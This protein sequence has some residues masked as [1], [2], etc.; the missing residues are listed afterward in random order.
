MK[1]CLTPPPPLPPPAGVGRG[2]AAAGGSTIGGLAREPALQADP[3][4]DSDPVPGDS[5]AGTSVRRPEEEPC[6]DPSASG[7]GPVTLSGLRPRING[8]WYAPP[9]GPSSPVDTAWSGTMQQA[10]WRC[11]CSARLIWPL[12]NPSSS[13]QPSRRMSVWA[14]WL[15]ARASGYD[16]ALLWVLILERVGMSIPTFKHAT[17]LLREGLAHITGA[18]WPAPSMHSPAMSGGESAPCGLRVG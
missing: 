2:A 16:A 7:P 10:L 15:P 5:H 11:A 9:R 1:G 8:A 12:P 3:D 17:P 14:P 13:R 6:P 18:C 4:E